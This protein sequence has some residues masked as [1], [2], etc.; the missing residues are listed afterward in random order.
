MM[1]PSLKNRVDWTPVLALSTMLQCW[2][3]RSPWGSL[4]KLWCAQLCSQALNLSCVHLGQWSLLKSHS[5]VVIIPEWVK[6]PVWSEH[7]VRWLV[8]ASNPQQWQIRSST[9]LELRFWG[10]VLRYLSSYKARG[11]GKCY[12]SPNQTSFPADFTFSSFWIP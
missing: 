8:W 4:S 12:S 1:D 10:V 5:P 2:G 3:W 9:V 6:P 11:S 7:D